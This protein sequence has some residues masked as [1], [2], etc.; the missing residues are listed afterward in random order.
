MTVFKGLPVKVLKP[1]FPSSCNIVDLNC[2]DGIAGTVYDYLIVSYG[3]SLYGL[4]GYKFNGSKVS[5]TFLVQT[6]HEDFGSKLNKA[7]R[8]ICLNVDASV[9]SVTVKYFLDGSSSGITA[10]SGDLA[11]GDNFISI[12]AIRFDTL[13]ISVSTSSA[14]ILKGVKARVRECVR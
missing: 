7:C 8:E 13:S 10:F 5:G 6:R 12:D 4:Y 11:G 1:S 9:T 14:I 3:A 2:L